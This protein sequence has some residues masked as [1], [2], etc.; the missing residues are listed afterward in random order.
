MFFYPKTAILAYLSDLG[1]YHNTCNIK[2]F[3]SIRP[4]NAI[5]DQ[6][7]R[8]YIREYIRDIKIYTNGVSNDK[9]I[10]D[11]IGLKIVIIEV[12]TIKFESNVNSNTYREY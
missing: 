12:V 1:C 2:I 9:F 8:E 11:I 10:S 5:I 4:I 6:F 3:L 7:I